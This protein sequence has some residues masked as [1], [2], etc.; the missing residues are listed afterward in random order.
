MQHEFVA[1]PWSKVRA[2]L[3]IIDNRELLVLFDYYS[4]YVEVAHL[5]KATSSSVIHKI[6]EKFAQYGVLVAVVTDNS[7]QFA[8]AEFAL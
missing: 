5:T 8:S 7:L 3:C 4:N 6:K 1:R 2:G